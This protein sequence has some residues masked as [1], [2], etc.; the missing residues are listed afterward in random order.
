AQY[1]SQLGPP[2]RACPAR[3]LR[4][5]IRIPQCRQHHGFRPSFGE[6]LFRRVCGTKESN[7]NAKQV[8]LSV[9]RKSNAA[10]LL[11]TWHASGESRPC[12]PG[13]ARKPGET[14]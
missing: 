2:T 5:A 11:D 14:G 7:R 9:F 12:I 4:S 6:T 1:G 13:L 10:L 3:L 8:Q